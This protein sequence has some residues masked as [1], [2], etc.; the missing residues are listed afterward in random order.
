[1]QKKRGLGLSNRKADFFF[2]HEKHECTVEDAR[3]K[4]PLHTET[5]CGLRIEFLHGKKK[6]KPN[7]TVVVTAYASHRPEEPGYEPVLLSLLLD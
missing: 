3:Y 4:D 1:M 6:K 2:V 7:H 5:V